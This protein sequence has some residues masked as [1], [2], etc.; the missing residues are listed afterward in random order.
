MFAQRIAWVVGNSEYVD[1]ILPNPVN[2]AQLVSD[3]LAALGFDVRLDKN[4]ATYGDFWSSWDE[5]EPEI[6]DAEVFLFYYAGHGIQYENENY[7]IPTAAELQDERRIG[8]ECFPIKSLINEY[9]KFTDS[10]AFVVV[11]DACRVNP[12]ERKW[13]RS[14]GG[15]A[16][17]SKVNPPTG[18]LVAYSTEYGT[19]AADGDGKY[20]A[21]AEAFAK[22]IGEPGRSLQESFQTIRK[23][24]L[25]LSQKRQVPVEENKL[26]ERLVLRQLPDIS[27]VEFQNIL[28]DFEELL[29]RGFR[30]NALITPDTSV[31]V[32]A[33]YE[34]VSHYAIEKVELDSTTRLRFAELT[35]YNELYRLQKG[36]ISAS[37][38][39]G[40]LS[41]LQDLEVAPD[42]LRLGNEFLRLLEVEEAPEFLSLEELELMD[43]SNPVLAFVAMSGVEPS[44]SSF[45]GL[46]VGLSND[47]SL[48]S[49]FLESEFILAIEEYV[50]N[51]VFFQIVRELSAD[52]VI[53]I[54][55][56]YDGFYS[57]V[58]DEADRAIANSIILKM[59]VAAVL[60][61][62]SKPG[63]KALEKYL[64]SR[65]GESIRAWLKTPIEY[66]SE[67]ITETL[68][69]Y[70]IDACELLIPKSQKS[71]IEQA[72]VKFFQREWVRAYSQ[73]S[74]SYIDLMLIHDELLAQGFDE[75]QQVS[76]S[77]QAFSDSLL[78]KWSCFVS[79]YLQDEE[80]NDLD[81][82]LSDFLQWQ[83]LQLKG[84]FSISQ[85]SMET[86]LDLVENEINLLRLTNRVSTCEFSN[87]S[88][89]QSTFISDNWNSS[90]LLHYAQE[91]WPYLKIGGEIAGDLGIRDFK[92]RLECLAEYLLYYIEPTDL[93]CTEKD[94]LVELLSELAEMCVADESLSSLMPRCL[95]L[96]E[97]VFES[98]AWEDCVT[99][100][101]I[102][103][104]L[105]SR[106]VE[107]FEILNASDMVEGYPIADQVKSSYQEELAKVELFED[108]VDFEILDFRLRN[109]G[110]LINANFSELFDALEKLR[111][112]F[113]SIDY[114]NQIEINVILQIYSLISDIAIESIFCDSKE[115]SRLRGIVTLLFDELAA[116]K[117]SAEISEHRAQAA[118]L[119]AQ[120]LQ[121]YYQRTGQRQEGATLITES[122]LEAM[123]LV[124]NFWQIQPLNYLLCE[125]YSCSGDFSEAIQFRELCLSDSSGYWEREDLWQF[126]QDQF[127]DKLLY[128][129]IIKGEHFN[130]LWS[131]PVLGEF[132]GGKSK[133]TVENDGEFLEI[134][135][136]NIPDGAF[137]IL[138]F[139]GSTLEPE[140]TIL[141]AQKESMEWSVT[142]LN[143]AF[144]FIGNRTDSLYVACHRAA[145][146][147]VLPEKSDDYS[148]V[149]VWEK[150]SYKGGNRMASLRIP[151][152]LFETGGEVSRVGFYIKNPLPTGHTQDLKYI[153]YMRSVD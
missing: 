65:A 90:A 87:V 94:Q 96:L 142:E 37:K 74:G 97:D 4:L 76:P 75:I 30:E 22:S 18:T 79:S 64:R 10:T 20:S 124:R 91:I 114:D 115:I 69:L 63:G 85:I 32:E 88:R 68:E 33:A 29:I 107:I 101:G 44:N 27:M 84:D 103:G 7:L 95:L 152:A 89:I 16:G 86:W 132:E 8:N 113:Q 50:Q 11:L 93:D 70:L 12:F 45:I 15:G 139:S 40:F 136:V 122:A 60:V 148:G 151:E 129:G 48:K 49:A 21:Y 66:G 81:I 26:T 118:F 51:K 47:E 144:E 41:V 28:D 35:F 98:R 38:Y 67:I 83:W 46:K 23:T 128:T 131:N 43:F 5:L 146:G 123:K 31:G 153:T 80:L 109:E 105:R 106:Y 53:Q 59:M 56:A 25:E 62:E 102:Y 137:P 100:I 17:L 120:G 73:C 77:K 71:A 116:L 150:H 110:T 99:E 112:E 125:E 145:Q 72:L 141:I 1:G 14:Y 19:T 36:V 127:I 111:S 6:Q 39:P 108:I 104:A 134:S 2:D 34:L 149:D 140:N 55:I 147:F 3:S 126:A 92:S 24:V 42:L 121:E 133:F 57:E 9:E 82:T 117:K 52:E 135:I 78:S 138:E 58:M 61:V 13:S 54:M 130:E 119:Y 143:Q